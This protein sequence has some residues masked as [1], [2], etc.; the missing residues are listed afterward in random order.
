MVTLRNGKR[1]VCITLW[2]ID[3]NTVENTTKKVIPTGMFYMDSD[4]DYIVED[5][6]E[7]IRMALEWINEDTTE[8]RSMTISKGGSKC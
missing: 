3:E 6:D 2:R 4:G 7:Y 8:I 5:I 1:T